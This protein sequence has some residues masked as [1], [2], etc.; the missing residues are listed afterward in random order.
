[1]LAKT[2]LYL[3]VGKNGMLKTFSVKLALL[4]ITQMMRTY[5]NYLQISSTY[6]IVIDWFRAK[7][8]FSIKVTSQYHE[9]VT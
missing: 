4:V 8:A 2:S 5:I 3:P 1:M 7:D 6:M 9:N